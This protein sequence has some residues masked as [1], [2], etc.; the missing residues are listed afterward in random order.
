MYMWMKAKV[1]RPRM[2]DGS[3]A[4]SRVQTRTAEFE[5]CVARGREQRCKH[6]LGPVPRERSKLAWKREDDVKVLHVEQPTT[7]GAYPSFLCRELTLW[8]VAIAARVID[9]TAVPTEMADFN[10]S[11]KVGRATTLDAVQHAT[12]CAG[13]RS[14]ALKLVAV[15]PDDDGKIKGRSFAL[16]ARVHDSTQRSQSLQGVRGP[17]H[18]FGRNSRVAAGRRYLCMT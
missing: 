16:D 10:V 14:A 15:I 8:A 12:L 18:R 6:D 11:A 3:D 7:A 4:Q 5:Q 13:Q 17:L 2:K 9:W 1:A